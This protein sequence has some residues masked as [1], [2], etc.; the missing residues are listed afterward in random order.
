MHTSRGVLGIADAHWPETR[1]IESIARAQGVEAVVATEVSDL[2]A[3]RGDLAVVVTTLNAQG[4]LQ[5]VIQNMKLF[6][7]KLNSSFAWM[8][9]TYKQ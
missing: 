3:R 2:V 6:Q 8:S 7:M 1:P 4:S 5:D 9:P